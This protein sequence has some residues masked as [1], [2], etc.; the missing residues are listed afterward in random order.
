MSRRHVATPPQPSTCQLTRKTEVRR[1]A[2]KIA[3]EWG[4]EYSR[5]SPAFFASVE[6]A[7]KRAI[8][9]LVLSNN[10][11]KRLRKTLR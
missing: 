3:R 9:Q 7:S 11:G 5:V 8:A 4:V 2:H 6:E 10:Q 1:Y